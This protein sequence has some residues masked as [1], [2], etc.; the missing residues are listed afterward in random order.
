MSRTHAPH[1][2]LTPT[3]EDIVTPPDSEAAARPSVPL[4]QASAPS[5]VPEPR[6]ALEEVSAKY[7]LRFACASSVEKAPARDPSA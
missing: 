5:P 1:L 6:S 2:E 7:R 4:P 3:H